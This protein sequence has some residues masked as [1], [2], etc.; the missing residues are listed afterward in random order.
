MKGKRRIEQKNFDSFHSYYNFDSRFC[1]VGKGH[2][3]GGVEGLVK[4][5][6][7]NFMVPIPNAKNYEELNNQLLSDCIAYGNHVISGKTNSVNEL[8]EMEKKHLIELPLVPFENIQI[9]DP[10]VDKFSTILVD[11]NHY[12]V[13]CNYAGF[14][15]KVQL[16]Y[17]KVHVYYNSKHI[18]KHKRVFDVNNWKLKPEHFLK[19]L[20]RK[21]GAFLSSKVI[22]EWRPKWPDC[23]EKLLS[24]MKKNYSESGAIKEF[25]SVLMLYQDYSK[26]DVEAAV[27]LSLENN[28]KS[29]E[30]V[31]HILLHMKGSKR[32]DPLPNWPSTIKADVKIYDELGG[33]V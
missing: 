8:F 19:V 12:S 20:Q 16:E 4:F 13:P 10:K 33:N 9:L 7:R 5:A 26:E 3:K 18:A 2:E 17:D 28:V 23:L 1:N 15:V 11:K 6:R 24:C 32:I 21:P 25:I 30:G 27:E 14:K 31:K 22:R 29:C